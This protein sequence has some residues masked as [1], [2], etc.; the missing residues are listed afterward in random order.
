[1]SVTFWATVPPPGNQNGN[2][3][4]TLHTVLE[5]VAH[6]QSEVWM[7]LLQSF[8]KEGLLHLPGQQ[9]LCSCCISRDTSTGDGRHYRSSEPCTYES[10]V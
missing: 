10:A 1:M 5:L 7:S 3:A 6:E 8:I 9:N 2:T 4:V